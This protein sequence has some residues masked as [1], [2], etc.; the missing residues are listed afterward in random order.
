VGHPVGERFSSNNGM[1]FAAG[2][3]QMHSAEPSPRFETKDDPIH[4]KIIVTMMGL[5]TIIAAFAGAA[6]R[7]WV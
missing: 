3:P 1:T 7:G 5:L 4:A 6:T 2:S